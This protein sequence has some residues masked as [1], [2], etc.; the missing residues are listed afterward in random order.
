MDAYFDDEWQ[1][2]HTKLIVVDDSTILGSTNWAYSGLNFHHNADVIIRNAVFTR[3]MVEFYRE[4]WL[5]EDEMLPGD[6]FIYKQFSSDKV[7]GGDKLRASGYVNLDSQR[8]RGVKVEFWV[9]DSS[10]APVIDRNEVETDDE[11][12]YDIS[13]K[14]PSKKGNYRVWLKVVHLGSETVESKEITVT[15]K[16]DGGNE[17]N[18]GKLLKILIISVLSAL[19]VLVL[20]FMVLKKKVNE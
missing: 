14:M 19:V 3:D 7:V 6:I 18:N 13:L 8:L 12:K 9:E 15:E 5:D 16:N 20:L 10:G 11:G 17:W 1:I 2:T 4:Y